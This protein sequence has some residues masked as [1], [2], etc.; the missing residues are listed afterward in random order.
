MF[1]N[2]YPSAP[3]AKNGYCSQLIFIPPAQP[4]RNGRLERFHKTMDLEYWQFERPSSIEEGLD[5]LT[6]FLNYHNFDRP[7]SSLNFKAP[8]DSFTVKKLPARFWEKLALES[9]IKPQVGTVEVIRMVYNDGEVDL[10]GNSLYVSPLLAGQYVWVRFNVTGS[11]SDGIVV[12]QTRKG[13]DNIIA[14]FTHNLDAS[15]REPLI[16]DV[17]LTD[18]LIE[19]KPN[20]NLDEDQLAKQQSRILKRKSHLEKRRDR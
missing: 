17:G 8:A 3:T 12:F 1:L 19:R 10:W 11:Q 6:D 20:Q 18:Y 13:E 9:E 4:W 5:G 14:N 15:T 2:L 7:H 16:G